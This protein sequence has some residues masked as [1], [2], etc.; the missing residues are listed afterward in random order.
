MGSAWSTWYP[1]DPLEPRAL[2]PAIAAAL[3]VI[4]L[5]WK[6]RPFTFGKRGPLDPR[7][8]EA[9][10]RAAELSGRARALAL[11]EAGALSLEAKRPTAAFGYYLRAT[12]ADPS[13]IEP[14]RGIVRALGR[15]RAS[16]ER[17]L[18]RQLATLEW[19]GEFVPAVSAC[20]GE[21]EALHRRSGERARADALIKV[22]VL[23][24]AVTIEH[25]P[26]DE[27]D[28]PTA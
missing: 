12:R 10:T 8:A 22:I 20:L 19:S 26:Q 2:I 17:V 25:E 27:R 16:L 21:L 7:I 11:C 5:L 24:P 13:A 1:R 28:A 6:M 15:K 9:R 4:F 23:L 3:F 14:I 18:W